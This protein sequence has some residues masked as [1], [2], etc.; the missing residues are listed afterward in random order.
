MPEA[1]CCEIHI[2]GVL[3]ERWIAYFAPFMLTFGEDETIITGT[4]YDQ[5]ELFGLLLKIRDVGL[6]LISFAPVTGNG[7][8]PAGR[9]SRGGNA[10]VLC[11]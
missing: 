2:R 3:D 5:A 4:I 1:T 6:T 9:K 11:I 10:G 8:T 7:E